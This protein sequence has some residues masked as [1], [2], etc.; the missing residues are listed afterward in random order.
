MSDHQETPRGIEPILDKVIAVV[1]SRG[2]RL[3][4]VVAGAVWLASNALGWF[5]APDDDV[6]PS[7]PRPV[8][9]PDAS[10]ARAQVYQGEWRA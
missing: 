5:A 9:R 1:F 3:A 4:A 2:L 10:A 6:H 8:G 7:P